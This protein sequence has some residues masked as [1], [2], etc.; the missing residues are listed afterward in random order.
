MQNRSFLLFSK[1]LGE[2]SQSLIVIKIVFVLVSFI[3]LHLVIYSQE[4]GKEGSVAGRVSMLDVGLINSIPVTVVS[5][6]NLLYRTRTDQNG[7]FFFSNLPVGK[8]DLIVSLASTDIEKIRQIK[9]IPG[10]TNIDMNLGT[11]CDGFSTKGATDAEDIRVVKEAVLEALQRMSLAGNRQLVIST[12]NLPSEILLED[13]G[14]NVVFLSENSIRNRNFQNKESAL[15]VTN[16]S[17]RLGCIGITLVNSMNNLE[18]T[19]SNISGEGITLEYLLSNS[20]WIGRKVGG[21]IS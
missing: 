5:D 12:V 4:S 20:K 9:V 13:F 11:A 15:R 10:I 3:S 16:L 7:K 14:S 19:G 6:T 21:W 1:I 2:F 17:V 8:Y 18:S